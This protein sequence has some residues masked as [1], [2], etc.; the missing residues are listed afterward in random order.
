MMF[1]SNS[2]IAYKCYLALSRENLNVK[3]A[4]NKGIDHPEHAHRLIIA[5]A[6]C[7][8]ERL[9]APFAMVFQNYS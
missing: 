4:N 1:Q 5:F 8:L 6:V 7:L 3:F 9:I 2:A